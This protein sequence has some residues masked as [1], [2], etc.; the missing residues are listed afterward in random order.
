MLREIQLKAVAY[1]GVR[2]NEFFVF[3]YRI[4]KWIQKFSEK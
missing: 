2:E 1:F 4:E 3:V